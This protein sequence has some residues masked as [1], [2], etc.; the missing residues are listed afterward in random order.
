MEKQW[1]FKII[2]SQ[3]TYALGSRLSKFK[4]SMN[5]SDTKAIAAKHTSGAHVTWISPVSS[6]FMMRTP[7]LIPLDIYYLPPT[8]IHNS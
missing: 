4:R 3:N 6:L 5:N 2:D 1:H 8:Q 7:Q